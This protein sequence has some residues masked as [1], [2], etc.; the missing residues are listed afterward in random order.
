MTQANTHKAVEL[1]T[2]YIKSRLSNKITMADLKT[3]TGYS[4]R[5]LQLLF[6]KYFSKTPF[7][8]IEEQRLM[9]AYDLIKSHKKTRKTTDAALDVGYKHLGRFSVNFKARFGIHP[10]VL[11]KTS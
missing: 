6:Q 3:F 7:E 9:L 2:Q 5:S 4:E 8:Y 1:A 11:A 10:S